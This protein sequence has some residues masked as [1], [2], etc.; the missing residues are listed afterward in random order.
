MQAGRQGVVR[1]PVH[2]LHLSH[3]GLP[4]ARPLGA[5]EVRGGR[6][7]AAGRPEQ[8]LRSAI[9]LLCA[10][11]AA[12]GRRRAC[13]PIA[14]LYQRHVGH[15]LSRGKRA[16]LPGG[17]QLRER[18]MGPAWQRASLFLL[19]RFAGICP[20]SSLATYGVSSRSSSDSQALGQQLLP[21]RSLSHRR[22][23]RARSGRSSILRRSHR[24]QQALLLRLYRRGPAQ[25]RAHAR[26]RW[27]RPH[28]RRR[29][30]PPR[31]RSSGPRRGRRSLRL[32][33]RGGSGRRM[34]RRSRWRSAIPGISRKCA[35]PT[36]WPRRMSASGGR[37]PSAARRSGAVLH[38]I[39]PPN[40]VLEYSIPLAR[41]PFHAVACCIH[42][43]VCCVRC[44]NPF[45][46]MIELQASHLP[47]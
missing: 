36:S 41:D 45:P 11:A 13:R 26:S 19:S 14:A 40:L 28:P 18:R 35:G 37:A 15:R 5:C 4:Q 42:V 10:H 25:G 29:P 27:Q 34:R 8:P 33:R 17:S 21:C 44:A 1:L 30:G 43:C 23:C 24:R 22:T 16:V 46:Q 9:H 32:I 12:C 3:G 7:S 20:L 6:S 47:V 39:A 31:A 2:Q 38:L